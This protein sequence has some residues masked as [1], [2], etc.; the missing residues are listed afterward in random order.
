LSPGFLEGA[1][2][3]QSDS[4]NAYAT[5]SGALVAAGNGVFASQRI[6]DAFAVVDAGAPGVK[7]LRENQPVGVTDFSG[8][9][10]VPGLNSYQPYKISIDALDLPINADVPQTEIYVVPAERSGVVAS[11][12]VQK[13]LPSAEVIFVE[14]DGFF[15]TPGSVGVLQASGEPFVVGYDGRAFIK[16]LR[17]QNTVTIDLET[18]PCSAS[19]AFEEKVETLVTIGPVTCR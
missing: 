13:S 3:H 14:A 18:A 19:F 6:D 4:V 1:I 8:K 9:L 7:V 11:F 17:P 12:G 16:N 15:L 5:F 10:L 2:T